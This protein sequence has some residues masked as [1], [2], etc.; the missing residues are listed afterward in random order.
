MHYF[1]WTILKDVIRET[2]QSQSGTRWSAHIK[3][4]DPVAKYSPGH[5][6]ALQKLLS[7]GLTG[8]LMDVSITWH[9]LNMYQWP[10]FS[11]ILTFIDFSFVLQSTENKV[12]NIDGFIGLKTIR[13]R[14][15]EII[16]E[17]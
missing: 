3:S 14:W 12:S 8:K 15:P 6:A 16:K 5:I 10:P 9:L 11:I 13:N 4:V 2:L 17:L 7:T 1:C